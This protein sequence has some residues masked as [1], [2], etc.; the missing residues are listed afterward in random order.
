MI[1]RVRAIV[2]ELHGAHGDDEPLALDSFTTVLIVEALEDRLGVKLPVADVT[3]E[4]FATIATIARLAA[5]RA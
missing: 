1:A 2:A 3:P 4:H 5:G